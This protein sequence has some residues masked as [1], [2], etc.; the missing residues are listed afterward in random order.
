MLGPIDQGEPVVVLGGIHPGC[1]EIFA[2][3]SVRS[4][5][6]L[7]GKRIPIFAVN[8]STHVFLAAIIAHIGLDPR[9]DIEWVLE[10][11]WGRWSEMLASGEVDAVGAFPP[12]TYE[13]RD[14]GVGHV[15]LD[16][17]VD[18]PWRHYF[19]CVFAGNR[20]FVDAHPVASKR[21][22]RAL[23]KANQICSLE[24]ERAA[25][26]LVE[27]GGASR[28]D[29]ALRVFNELP[30]DAWRSYDPSDTMRF[31]ALRLREAGMLRATPREILARGADFRF[32]DELRRELKA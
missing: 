6:D 8:G 23:F 2:N 12:G 15:I 3:D 30:Y 17:T 29:Y 1:T 27:S 18:T 28:Y 10:P 24:P 31:F 22:L 13:L 11:D 19:C 9:R 14:A 20:D 25:R 26:L 7:R 5:R 4:I 21:V 16:T 32:L